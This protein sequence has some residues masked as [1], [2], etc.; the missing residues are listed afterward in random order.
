MIKIDL[1]EGDQLGTK[2]HVGRKMDA[3]QRTISL[4]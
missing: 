4:F 2:P 1:C 3:N